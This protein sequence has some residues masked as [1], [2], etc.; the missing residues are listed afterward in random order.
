MADTTI[1]SIESISEKSIPETL[2]GIDI[3]DG[4]DRLGGNWEIY[5]YIL[6][7]FR[8]NQGDAADRLEMLISN[9]QW[10]AA[11]HLAHSIKGS[12]GNLGAKRLYEKAA[13]LEQTC[14][15]TEAAAARSTLAEL[16]SCLE[17]VIVGLER[18]DESGEKVS[19]SHE[20]CLIATPAETTAL[21]HKM[22]LSLD[23]DL[24]EAQFCLAVLQQQTADNEFSA[25][26]QALKRALHDF[27]I[28]TAKEILQRSISMVA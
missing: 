22:L 17:E 27:D 23:C 3:T 20:S 1:D 19:E 21:L 9:G 12:G 28:Q 25:S 8:N 26:L 10:E 14:R 11:E 5:R 18:L 15:K 2:P 16:R 24:G 4:L 13:A 6:L 7:H